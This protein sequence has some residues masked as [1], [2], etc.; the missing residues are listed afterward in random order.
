MTRNRLALKGKTFG[1]LYVVEFSHM[2]NHLHS[3]WKCKC[4]CGK[5]V[6]VCGSNMMSGETK[7]CGC[8]IRLKN[9]K[10]RKSTFEKTYDIT[11]EDLTARYYEE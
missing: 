10:R 2:S 9:H 7:S 3:H 6:V 1:M 11:V 8:L 5:E 4:E